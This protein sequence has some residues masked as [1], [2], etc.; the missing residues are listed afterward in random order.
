MLDLN[1]LM[2]QQKEGNQ[3]LTTLTEEEEFILQNYAL[4]AAQGLIQVGGGKKESTT[5]IVINAFRFGLCLGLELDI[6]QG[7]VKERSK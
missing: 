2:K 1:A 6:S 7:K 5:N 3:I 4:M